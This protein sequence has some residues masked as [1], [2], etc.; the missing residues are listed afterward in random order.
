MQRVI[1]KPQ[2]ILAWCISLS[3]LRA[4]PT[5]GQEIHQNSQD[6]SANDLA[7]RLEAAIE[8]RKAGDPVAVGQANRRVIALSLVQL[9]KVR[10]DSNQY[11]EAARLCR[12]SLEFEDTAESR[13][14]LAVADL[15]AK[16]TSDAVEQ[17]TTATEM[18]SLN[19]LAWTVRGEALLRSKEYAGAASA[20][21]R[22]IDIKEDTEPLYALGMAQLGL[23]EKHQAADTFRK[24]LAM[25]GDAGWSRVLVG[26]A[27][28]T[29]HLP[30]EAI[31]EF[32]NALRIEPR[33]P[34]AHYF[35]GR[36]LLQTNDW[37]PT[38]EIKSHLQEEL[39]LNPRHFLA[40]YL[41]GIFARMGRDF[42]LSDRYL[43]TATELNPSLP[44]TWMYLGLN[45]RDRNANQSAERY[46]RKAVSL[47]ERG[48]PKEH[49]SVRQAY[50]VLGRILV[51]SGRKEEGE[52]VLKEGQ[53][54]QLEEQQAS[55]AA[56]KAKDPQEAAV[57]KAEI[58]AGETESPLLLSS[59]QVTKDGKPKMQ[60][61]N[62]EKQ[63]RAVLA[64]SLNDLAT[65][66]A[67]QSKYDPAL[68]HYREAAV[69]DPH[70]PGL[71]R[72]LGLA[73]F[74]AGKP[75]EAIPLLSKVVAQS[76]SD[77][78]TRAA[79]GMA[80]AETQNFTR[81]VQTI[82]PIV[83]QALQD[84]QLGLAWAKSLAETG[85]RAGAARALKEIERADAN[86]GLERLIQF[87]QLW[88]ELGDNNHATESFRRALV[89]DPENDDAK[90]ALHLAKCP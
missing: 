55:A 81:A 22:S 7:H 9:A 72:N 11:D 33:A 64:S 79:L 5:S 3:C 13:V 78:Q 51:S 23:G 6:S 70:V 45:A 85:N 67:L 73:V 65:A 77:A 88:Q 80:Y 40:N 4:I 12:D 26:R 36:T 53:Q 10:L 28:L 30:Q 8:A 47:H 82:A 18:D 49:L 24:M 84:P 48:D 75:A 31:A 71:Q 19:A 38:L 69:W 86:P 35:W 63:L 14:E 54:L 41:L 44:E 32:Q 89:I 76:P 15:Y 2:L 62:S 87:G 74:F 46:L 66:E 27:Y 56:L 34:E 43:H 59:S 37:L 21:Q 29:Q 50:F 20:M 1:L 58:P 42:E 17:A 39:K 57:D 16:K 83:N 90:C 60:I 61:G 52:R 25:I 68:K